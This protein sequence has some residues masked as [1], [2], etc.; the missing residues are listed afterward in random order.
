MVAKIS[1][2][3]DPR[4][5]PPKEYSRFV[6]LTFGAALYGFGD[7]ERVRHMNAR[8]VGKTWAPMRYRLAL[9]Q[10]DFATAA[11]IRRHPG[12]TD[13]ERW[14]FRCTM[15]LHLIWLH[16]YA[17][18]FH[19]YQDRWRAINFPK[20]LPSKLRYHPVGDPTDDPPLVVLEQGVG[21]CLLALM[22]LRAAPPRQ[23]AALPKFR[24]LIQR[25]LPESRFFPSSDLPEELSGAPAICSADL[26]GRAWRQTGTFKPPSSL[27]TPIRD[28]GA[29]PV[30][31]ICWR[32]G[33]GQNR[34]EER[35]IPLHLFLD[36][37]PHEGRY[38]PLQFDL[39]ASERALL[40]KDRRVQPP[41]INVTKSPD[42][43]LQLVRRL[44]GVISIDSANWHF[45]AA[46]DVPFLALMNRRAHW[47]WGPD[48]DAAWTYPT[49][50]TIKKTD[51]SQDRAR[52][53]MHQA[54]RAFSQRPVPMPVPLANHGRRP[55]LVAGLPRSRTS[56]TMRILAAHGV[57]VGET[58]Q[59]TSANPH[60][61]FENLVLKNSV[62][63]KLLKELGADPNGVE[64]LPDSSNMPVLPGLDQRLLQALTD[65]GYDGARPWAFKD[66]KLTLLWPIFASAFPD[67]HWIIPQRDRQAVIDSLSKVHFMRRHSSDPEYWAMFCAAYQQRLDALAR[68]G[69]RVSVI[70]TDALVKGDHAALSEVIRAAGVPPEPDV[71]R[72]AIDPALARQ[73][74]AQP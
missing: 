44:A 70:D 55:I 68:S 5:L 51:L 6:F 42:I 41:L 73:T 23:I 60:G 65:Q 67:A 14:D 17:W 12:I 28:Q 71:F 72:T 69:A 9:R 39:T 63:K 15:G 57:W 54:E 37:L 29:K 59:A 38:V 40:A 16:R 26:F 13:K 49:A 8:F 43:V 33:S 27:T 36:L 58:M 45:A 61:F 34:R 50:T 47:F 10:K 30:Y 35:Q 1:Q 20:I 18:G 48:A 21:E 66:P 7:L 24:T 25:V 4:H 53:W 19:F 62:L 11:R 56:M 31:G 32:G 46:A 64:P 2:I 52:Q 3:A 22:H 74:K